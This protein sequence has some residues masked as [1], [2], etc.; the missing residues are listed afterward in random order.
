MA[1]IV[2]VGASDELATR[3]TDP[4]LTRLTSSCGSTPI[5]VLVPRDCERRHWSTAGT[6]R[7]VGDVHLDK[8]PER[9]SL[10]A[11]VS[12][13]SDLDVILAT[14]SEAG[15]RSLQ[16]LDGTFACVLWD[17]RGGPLLLARDPLGVQTIFW[18]QK[19]G[20]LQASSHIELLQDNGDLD[21][22]FV[23][24]FLVHGGSLDYT[25]R[26]GCNRCRPGTFVVTDACGSSTSWE[27]WSPTA[28]MEETMNE[29]VAASTYRSLLEDSLKGSLQGHSTWL[30]LSGGLDSSSI[31]CLARH[32]REKHIIDS[33]LAGCVTF[34]DELSPVDSEL[35]ALVAAVAGIVN[36][37]LAT[38]D[39]WYRFPD[40]AIPGEPG[41]HYLFAARIAEL[42]QLLRDRGGQVL[43]SGV[44]GDELLH[45]S[46]LY[47]ADRCAN[48]SLIKSVTELVRWASLL[49][50]PAWG[51]VRH[52]LVTA[53]GI[54]SSD[55]PNRYIPAWV[56]PSFRSEYGLADRIR[57]DAAEFSPRGCK[58]RTEIAHN[59]RHTSMYLERLPWDSRLELRY[60]FLSRPLVEL[61]LRLPPELKNRPNMTKYLMRQALRGILPER[62]CRRVTK[63]GI[64]G[65][66]AWSL[67]KRRDEVDYLLV[68]SQLSERGVIDPTLFRSAV[69]EAQHGEQSKPGL[70]GTLS[71]ETWLTMKSGRWLPAVRPSLSP[72]KGLLWNRNCPPH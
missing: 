8:R 22:D 1:F 54:Q 41:L 63:D 68:H 66:L 46:L 26:R 38:R 21:M 49:G 69:Q 14:V 44:G 60:P 57:A 13:S 6:W 67:S 39:A 37:R 34:V 56:T 71:L 65:R 25:V 72:E 50:H 11:D 7:A 12:S 55:S 43:L 51:S 28:F 18:S 45:W 15:P 32:L 23:A 64:D 20:R 52:L 30:L 17:S 47:L 40:V 19:G 53:F 61:S 48:G 42:L 29:E 4:R 70:L 5:T 62:V 10:S 58:Y 2:T 33:S 31:A 9:L 24:D 3:G 59:L 36:E 27:Y 35:S 16:H